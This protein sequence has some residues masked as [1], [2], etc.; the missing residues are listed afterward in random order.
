M[1]PGKGGPLSLLKSKGF[2]VP[3]FLIIPHVDFVSWGDKH[4]Y[5]KLIE[6]LGSHDQKNIFSSAKEFSDSVSI[7]ELKI[8]ETKLYAVRSSAH[9]EDSLH[10][11]FAGIFTTKLFTPKA[12]ITSRI[13]EIWLSLYED[14][15]FQYCQIQ[16]IPWS[17]LQMDIIIQEMIVGDKSGI[18]FQSN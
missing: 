15:S 2:R 16:N 7:P 8:D 5:S 4:L 10:H 9:L 14:K 13:K 1:L 11:S 18:L 17:S 12:S 6:A 3:E